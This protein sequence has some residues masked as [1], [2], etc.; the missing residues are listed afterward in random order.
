LEAAKERQTERDHGSGPE[1]DEHVADEESSISVRHGDTCSAT[2]KTEGSDARPIRPEDVAQ[3]EDDHREQ[4][5][6]QQ[7]SYEPNP[8]AVEVELTH[9]QARHVTSLKGHHA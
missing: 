8:H 3:V 6:D 2:E 9:S 4:P 5:V 1:N 7:D